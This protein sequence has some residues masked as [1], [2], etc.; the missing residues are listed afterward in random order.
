M[1]RD[2]YVNEPIVDIVRRKLAR[3]DLVSMAELASACDAT[4]MQMRGAM[5]RLIKGGE[6]EVVG[7]S[8]ATEY[9][10][11]QRRAA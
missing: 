3:F 8:T 7:A 6:V 9:R 2:R 11:K 10:L 5:S 4:E 1:D